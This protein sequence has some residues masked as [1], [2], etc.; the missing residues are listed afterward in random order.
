MSDTRYYVIGLPVVIAID[1]DGTVRAEVDLSEAS[2]L[3]DASAPEEQD[4]SDDLVD[5]DIAA[6]DAALEAGKVVVS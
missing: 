4:N 2:D 6:I 5:A 1:A 3:R